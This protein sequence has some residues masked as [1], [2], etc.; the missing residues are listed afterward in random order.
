[1]S[2]VGRRP[3]GGRVVLGGLAHVTPM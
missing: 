2:L 1:M 3:R